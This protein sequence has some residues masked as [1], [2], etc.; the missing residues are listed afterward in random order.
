M[1]IVRKQVPHIR[2][3]QFRQN[4]HN[5]AMFHCVFHDQSIPFS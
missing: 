2:I 3:L 4:T 1:V 5:T